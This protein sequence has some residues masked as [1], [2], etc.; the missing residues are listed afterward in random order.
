MSKEATQVSPLPA[1]IPA[2]TSRSAR[3]W[4]FLGSHI[5]AET[6]VSLVAY[7]IALSVPGLE[8]KIPLLAFGGVL[9]VLA[10]IAKSKKDREQ[11]GRE[12]DRDA[13]LKRVEDAVLHPPATSGNLKS[14]TIEMADEIMQDLWRHGWRM[15]PGSN[16]H[17]PKSPLQPEIPKKPDEARQ[18]A[19]TRSVFFRSRFGKPLPLLRDELA[20]AH[21]VDERLDRVCEELR[22]PIIVGT[23]PRMIQPL[24]I[25][26]SSETLRLLASQMN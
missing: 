20:Q 5:A 17:H 11:E 9:L 3:F 2:S 1:T 19:D 25:E 10:G 8:A 24:E 13:Q 21:F 26:D 6:I 18:W 12:E 7:A 16:L 14:R 22:N 23:A 4:K 15:P